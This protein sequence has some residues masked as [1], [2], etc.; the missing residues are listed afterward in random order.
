MANANAFNQYS[1]PNGFGSS[2]ALAGAQSFNSQGPLGGFGASAANSQS[3]G[4]NAGPGG[5]SGTAGL[6]GSQNYNLPNGHH[7][8][9]AYGGTY[10]NTNGQGTGG[11]AAS[12][13]YD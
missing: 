6:S 3:Q 8:N 2:A 11:N 1:G 7:V 4:F 13:T 9:L 12:I 10:G 5:F